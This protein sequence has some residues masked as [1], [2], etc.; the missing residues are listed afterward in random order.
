MRTLY[1]ILGRSFIL[2]LFLAIALVA[3]QNCVDT[4][5]PMTSHVITPEPWTYMSN[6][7]LP[8]EYDPYTICVPFHI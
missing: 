7:E 8:K 4:S 2:L 3:A 6:D 1:F 5:I